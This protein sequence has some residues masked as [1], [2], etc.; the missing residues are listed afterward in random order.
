MKGAVWIEA[1]FTDL[2][3]PWFDSKITK[4]LYF[5]MEN[6]VL[7]LGDF[8]ANQDVVL[9]CSLQQKLRGRHFQRFNIDHQ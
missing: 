6:L 7:E 4:L 2:Y 9:Q 3:S 5:L 1:G 8:T